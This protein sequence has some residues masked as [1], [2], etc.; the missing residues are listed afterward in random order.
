MI[1]RPRS[2]VMD[3]FLFQIKHKTYICGVDGGKVGSTSALH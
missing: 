1:N 2:I 3:F